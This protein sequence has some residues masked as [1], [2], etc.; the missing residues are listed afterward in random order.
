MKSIFL[1][2]KK[3]HVNMTF[4]QGNWKQTEEYEAY[5]SSW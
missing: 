5:M 2:N 3:M 4:G 1:I